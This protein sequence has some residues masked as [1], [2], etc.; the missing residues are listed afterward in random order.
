MQ[1]LIELPVNLE[2]DEHLPDCCFGGQSDEYALAITCKFYCYK[3]NLYSL[4]G[5]D[6]NIHIWKSP[7]SHQDYHKKQTNRDGD[8]CIAWNPNATESFMFV[9]W[10]F[11][12][13]KQW[14]IWG[15]QT[16]QDEIK[17]QPNLSSD[18]VSHI[19]QI[20]CMKFG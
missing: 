10:G 17:K 4:N 12:I 7:F 19:G 13:N 6:K 20:L 8:N 1:Q 3:T 18:I 14:K 15:T 11:Y 2:D 5:T 9:T 16:S